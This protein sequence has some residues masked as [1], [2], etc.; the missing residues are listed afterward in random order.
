MIRNSGIGKTELVVNELMPFLKPHFRGINYV[1]IEDIIPIVA[2]MKSELTRDEIEAKFDLVIAQIAGAAQ[3]SE[4][5]AVDECHWLFPSADPHPR[6]AIFRFDSTF[7]L[8]QIVGLK[9]I[10]GLMRQGKKL[11]FVSWLHPQDI[12]L[13]ASERHPDRNYYLGT[14]EMLKFFDIPVFELKSK[15]ETM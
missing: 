4:V 10:D 13:M 5:I 6:K 1:M 14:P 15:P 11:I 3:T 8:K 12:S 7:A 2:I 9:L